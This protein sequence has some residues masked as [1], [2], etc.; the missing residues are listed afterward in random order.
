MSSIFKETFKDLPDELRDELEKTYLK[1]IRKY[2]QQ[3]FEVSEL[4]AAK[5]SEVVFR[6][7]EWHTSPSKTYTSFGT[8]LRDFGQCCRRF[9]NMSRCHDSIRFHIPKALNSIYSIRNRRG[10][11]HISGDINPNKMDCMYIIHSVK[12]I[13]CELI[14]ILHTLN[15]NKAF[16]LVQSI[17]SKEIT[18]IW[19]IGDKKRILD[20]KLDASD[21]TLLLLYS[22]YPDSVLDTLL[23]DWLEYKN[24]TRFKNNILKDLHERKLL[25]YDLTSKQVFISPI[26][27]THAEKILSK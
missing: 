19:T 1:L 2:R 4:N 17:I 15:I 27:L 22:E 9:E 14:R 3:Q 13:L 24:S 5:F 8:P 10:V 11:G 23:I 26:G 20:R 25:E 16:A 6:I 12:W 21:K 18:V 7:L